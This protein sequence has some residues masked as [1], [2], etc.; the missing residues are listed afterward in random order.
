MKTKIPKLYGRKPFSK[1]GYGTD[2]GAT[3]KAI[4]ARDSG[5]CVDCGSTNNVQSHHIVPVSK[6]GSNHGFN[7][8]SLCTRCHDIRH[9][10]LRKQHRNR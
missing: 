6:G 5:R 2:W 9:P 10:H 4:K 3:T 8:I 7:L 1:T